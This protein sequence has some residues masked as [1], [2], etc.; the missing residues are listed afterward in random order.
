MADERPSDAMQ[1]SSKRR[2]GGQMTKD[3]F[4][5]DDEDGVVRMFDWPSS[6]AWHL[7]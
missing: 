6:T 7:R 3:D 5:D 4:E 1:P 2:A